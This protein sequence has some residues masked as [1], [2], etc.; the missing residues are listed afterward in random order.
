MNHYNNTF[1]PN[2]PNYYQDN[3]KNYNNLNQNSQYVPPKIQNYNYPNQISLPTIEMLNIN[4]NSNTIIKENNNYQKLTNKIFH[5]DSHLGNMNSYPT[6][7]W[8]M[9]TW[10]CF[11]IFSSMTFIASYDPRTDLYENPVFE[12]F[13]FIVN[14]VFILGYIFGIQAFTQQSAE[15]SQTFSY[16]LIGFIASNII[17]FLIFISLYVGFFRYLCCILFIVVNFVLYYQNQEL[18]RLF[19]EKSEIRKK[20]DSTHQ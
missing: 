4:S 9:L 12:K 1:N 19:S 10:S 15:K 2:N 18:I 11:C 6:V 3:I 14:L 17:Y 13:N 16:I 20:L 8:I 7:L 5:I